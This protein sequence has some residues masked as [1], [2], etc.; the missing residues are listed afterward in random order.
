MSTAELNTANNTL[1]AQAPIEPVNAPEAPG[2][3]SRVNTRLIGRYGLLSM[4]AFN[5][6][7]FTAS[8]S[9]PIE[10]AVTNLACGAFDYT[11]IWATRK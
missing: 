5:H 3:L 4:N 11:A 1:D 2:I 10:A 8:A 6:V 7:A 9:S